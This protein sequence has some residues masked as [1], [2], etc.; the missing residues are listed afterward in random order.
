MV[1]NSPVGICRGA[2]HRA[3]I[4][5]AIASI[6][7][8]TT[9]EERLCADEYDDTRLETLAIHTWNFAKKRVQI[10]PETTDAL[11]GFSARYAV[12]AGFVS[13]VQIGTF[14]TDV[15]YTDYAIEDGFILIDNPSENGDGEAIALDLVFL[16]DQKDLSKWSPLAKQIFKL[17]MA[18]KMFPLHKKSSLQRSIMDEI[19]IKTPRAQS[20]DGQQQPPK[21]IER[22]RIV[23]V[24]RGRG[25]FNN[26]FVRRT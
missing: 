24:R 17:K 6:D 22:S 21:R 25:R 26:Q 4:T 7:N 20:K 1:S 12:P 9:T 3:G 5:L 18:E 8:P 14:R 13:V 23:E 10:S 19:E 15:L 16:F 11:F 2:L